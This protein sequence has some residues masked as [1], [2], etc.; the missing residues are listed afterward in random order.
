MINY[1]RVLSLATI[2]CFFALALH[3][4]IPAGT[5]EIR[6]PSIPDTLR[7][8]Q[9]RADWLIIHYWDNADEE[10]NRIQK[11]SLFLEQNLAN[12]FS[13]MPIADSLARG[14]GVREMM[15]RIGRENKTVERIAKL[16][17]A[18]LYE[19]DSPTYN[20]EAYLAFSDFFLNDTQ[21]KEM[22]IG[23]GTRTRMGF[24]RGQMLKNR[25]GSRASDFEFIDRDGNR[26]SLRETLS[27]EAE[28]LL[29]FYDVDCRD[30]HEYMRSLAEDSET[31]NRIA[32]GRLT[33]IAV[34][35][36]GADASEWL[37]D[38]SRYPHEWIV[39]RSPDGEI[40][41]EEIY[42][43]RRSPSVYHLDRE[44]RIQSKM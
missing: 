40:D 17:S 30:C 5:R 11:D 22:Q 41:S 34:E 2:L 20:E 4:E 36:Y 37:A 23:E 44:G 33:I 24:E 43:L 31:R 14:E 38:A 9:E 18:Y 16:G 21:G 25:V 8:P 42:V 32:D 19:L 26:R 15:A 35:A 10:L 27:P 29:I 13:I 7:T 1:R 12:Y 28:T 6:L 39:G 3:S